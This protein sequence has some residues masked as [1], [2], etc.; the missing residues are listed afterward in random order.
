MS[1]KSYGAFPKGVSLPTETWEDKDDRM[2]V[3]EEGSEKEKAS[4]EGKVK[5][6]MMKK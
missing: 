6:F 1:F 2:I 5:V 4:R 3:E